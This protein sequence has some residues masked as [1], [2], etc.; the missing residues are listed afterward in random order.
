MGQLSVC[1]RLCGMTLA[2]LGVFGLYRATLASHRAVSVFQ[3]VYSHS[4]VILVSLVYYCLGKFCHAACTNHHKKPPNQHA[5]QSRRPPEPRHSHIDLQRLSIP[6]PDAPAASST[7]QIVMGVP[8]LTLQNVW[9]L[10][11][12]LGFVFFITGYCF[13][14]IH[15]VC[16]ACAGM[17]MWV[18]SVDELICPKAPHSRVYLIMRSTTLLVSLVALGLVSTDLFSDPIVL[19]YVTSLDLY[20]IFFGLAFPVCAQYLLLLVRDTR[21]HCTLG[22]VLEA[23]EFGFPFTIFLGV[24][25]LCVAYGQRLQTRTDDSLIRQ[26]YL[27]ELSLNVTALGP[28]FY[29]WYHSNVTAMGFARTDGPFVLFYSL[30]PLLLTPALVG[31]VSAVLDGCTID[32]LLSLTLALTVERLALPPDGMVST[33]SIYGVACCGVAILVRVLGEY[34]P[35]LF[36]RNAFSMQEESPQLNERA[37]RERDRR[38]EQEALEVEELTREFTLGLDSP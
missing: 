8:R 33:L 2:L 6:C 13:L 35:P 34:K 25:H 14:G 3:A 1:A 22:T 23:C 16:L 19:D 12:G 20:S 5:R 10:V 15:P 31:Y 24:F 29:Y 21:Q 18:L 9:L 11:Y 32:P 26:D 7:T 4:V 38:M 28:D 30:A 37:I 17:A 27:E 36:D